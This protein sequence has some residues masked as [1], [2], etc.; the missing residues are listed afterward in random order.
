MEAR[1]RKISTMIF[2]FAI[3]M[4]LAFFLGSW[5]YRIYLEQTQYS[6][7]KTIAAV[8]CGRFYFLID[9]NTVSYTNGTLHFA[10]ENTVGT[11]ITQLT[12]ETALETQNLNITGLMSGAMVPVSTKIQ[13][14][15]WAH[16]YPRYCRGLN[17]KNLTF[18]PAIMS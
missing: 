1:S 15:D 18:M 5:L 13:I 12:V 17:W 10:I 9:E 11:P 2:L 4:L 6:K 16:V 8:E 14:T 7:E 3:F